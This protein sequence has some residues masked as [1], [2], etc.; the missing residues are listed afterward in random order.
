MQ[1]FIYTV[2][3]PGATRGHLSI[4]PV[5]VTTKDQAMRWWIEA[6]GYPMDTRYTIL[7]VAEYCD[8]SIDTMQ[9]LYDDVERAQNEARDL[10][11]YKR[12]REKYEH[13]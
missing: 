2:D 1:F 11:E 4:C 10:A 7:Q 9:L 13:V 8:V 5:S 3:T 6:N 12:L